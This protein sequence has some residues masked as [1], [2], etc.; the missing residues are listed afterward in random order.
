MTKQ[1]NRDNYISNLLGEV[2][3]RLAKDRNKDFEEDLQDLL[4][5]HPR[6]DT[7]ISLG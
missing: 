5:R 4:K 2:R 1:I 6:K 3:V 7:A